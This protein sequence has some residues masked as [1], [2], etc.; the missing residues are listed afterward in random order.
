MN[1]LI[2]LLLS[3]ALSLMLFSTSAS[4]LPPNSHA[5][6]SSWFCN[7]GF[8]RQGNQCNKVI[9]PKNAYVLGSSWFCNPGFK[10][11]GNQCNKVIPPKNAYV[12]GS[13]WF[14]NPG[15]KR[16][17]NQCIGFQQ[18]TERLISAQAAAQSVAN[19]GTLHSH[20][21]K[22]HSHPYPVKQG[23]QHRHGKTGLTGKVLNTPKLKQAATS[24][25]G[26]LHS[27][28]TKEHSHPYPVKQGVQHR[29]GKTGLTGKVLNTQIL[30]RVTKN[31]PTLNTPKLKQPATI[32]PATSLVPI[33]PAM[34][35]IPRTPLISTTSLMPTVPLIPTTSSHSRPQRS[36]ICS[37]LSV[38]EANA[39]YLAGH[40]YLDRDNDGLPCEPYPNRYVRPATPTRS[41]G[42]N[43]HYVNGYTRSNGSYVR[44]HTRCR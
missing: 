43:C 19:N 28:G 30:T 4:A 5:V 32:A 17:G 41:Y 8:K 20:G 9:P 31:T 21:T 23:V 22:E 39:L 37:E 29:H 15:F 1:K 13:S 6:G 10:R 12:L 27:H 14:C 44:G 26:T 3:S 40:S 16:Q 18:Q 42:S 35:L 7:P 36:Y 11:Q 34:P 38:S 2:T 25:N 33:N 24:N